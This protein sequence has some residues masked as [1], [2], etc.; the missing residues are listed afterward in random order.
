[1]PLFCTESLRAQ[2]G[3]NGSGLKSIDEVIQ[4]IDSLLGDIKQNSN[5]QPYPSTVS[6]QGEDSYEEQGS[7]RVQD[8]LMPNILLDRNKNNSTQSLLSQPT[9]LDD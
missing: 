9:N 6:P 5:N 7:F 2:G 4:G 3:G 1:M 8:E